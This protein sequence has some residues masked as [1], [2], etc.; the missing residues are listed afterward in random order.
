[1]FINYSR[2]NIFLFFIFISITYSYYIPFGNHSNITLN[3]F[4]FGSC[5][6]G[7]YSKR[8]DIFKTINENDPQMWLWLGDAAYVDQAPLIIQYLKSTISVNFTKAEEIFHQSKN[9]ECI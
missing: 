2:F 7:Y 4:A 8:L 6:Y 3:N 9:N 1:M 5:F